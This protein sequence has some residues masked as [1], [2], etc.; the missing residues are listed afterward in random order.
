MTTMTR[1]SSLTRSRAGRNVVLT[2]AIAGLGGLL[3]GYDTGVIAGALLFIKPAFHLGSFESGLVVSAVP[4][5]AIAGAAV[6]G[7]LSDLRG[8][9]QMIVL[10]AIVFAVGAL[11]SA[12]ASGAGVLVVAR[13][14]VGVAIGLASAVAPVYISEVAPPDVR[15][16]LVTLFQLSVTVGILTAYLVSL[17]FDPIDG[18]RWM[19]GL[20]AVPA[21]VLGLG[22]LRMPQ[23]PRWLVMVGQDYKARAI[24]SRIREDDPEAI[25]RELEEI[26]HSVAEQPGGW[27]DLLDPV[28]RAA[29]V[30]GVGL[31]ILQQVSGI[32][33]VIYYAPTI[34]QFTG[35]NSSSSAILAAVG[36]G[37]VNVG[38]TVVAIR[39]LDRAGRRPLLLGGTAV[40]SLALATLGASFLGG[41][42]STADSVI[43]VL[44]LMLY[45][46]AFAI[47]LGPIFWLLNAEIYPLAV[48][49]KAAAVGT[50][51]NWTFNGIVSLTFLLLI[52][53]V[54]QSGTFFIYAAIS[55]FT[56]LFCWRLVPETKGMHL[57]DI[58]AIFQ[59]RVRKPAAGLATP[60]PRTR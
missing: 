21:L 40:M 25:D 49:S 42:G 55:A 31:A 54:G 44:S 5:G 41:A 23:S 29:L 3:F 18:W 46:G 14:V 56:F 4:I 32:N 17:A 10:A 15:G 8:R 57:E 16:R 47:S 35:V 52:D 22:M 36:V 27:H 48:R 53:S 12:A 51:A 43:A 19:L 13:L 7:R 45:V 34:I 11:A 26:E 30:V 59:E 33:T 28:V 37:V 6:A 38:M 9:R 1:G 60:R 39:L 58:Q 50:M 20:G 2:A 24:L